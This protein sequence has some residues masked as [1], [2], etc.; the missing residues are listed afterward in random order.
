MQQQSISHTELPPWL[1]YYNAGSA[2]GENERHAR[3]F[4]ASS[5]STY[6]FRPIKVGGPH[7]TSPCISTL[8]F[9]WHAPLS[10]ASER[11]GESDGTVISEAQ[12]HAGADV[13]REAPFLATL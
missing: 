12:R 2:A 4:L 3:A 7:C 11:P 8:T 10:R 6:L 13:I 9:E 1:P 5:L